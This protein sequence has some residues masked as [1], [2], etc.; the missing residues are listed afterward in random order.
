VCV[1]CLCPWVSKLQNEFETAQCIY[2]YSSSTGQSRLFIKVGEEERR[3]LF[4]I[5]RA[6]AQTRQR[7]SHQ[8]STA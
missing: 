5:G 6:K 1:C 8:Q 7:G 2:T 4:N 3:V